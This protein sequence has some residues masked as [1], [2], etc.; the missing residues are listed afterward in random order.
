MPKNTELTVTVVV[1]GKTVTLGTSKTDAKGNVTLPKFKPTKAGTYQI[2]MTTAKGVKY[3]V[4]VVVKAA[5]K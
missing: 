1:N 5:K 3:F 4:K 2:Q